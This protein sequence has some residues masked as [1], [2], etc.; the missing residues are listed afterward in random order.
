MLDLIRL[1]RRPLFPP[2]GRDLCRQVALLTD[3]HE[4]Q[5]LLV[6]PSGLAV[7]VEYFVREHGVNGSGV[8]PDPVLHD[9]AEER[10]R[11][12]GLLDRTNL[13]TGRADQLPFRDEIFDVVVGELGLTSK[14]DPGEA[15]AELIRVTRPGGTVVLVQPS[16]KAPVDANR[17]KVL[18]EHLGARP[19][20]LVEWK[21]LLVDG[22]LEQLHTEDWS[23]EETAFR[24]QV[25]KPFP[26]FE[27]LFTLREKLG[28]LRRAWGRWGWRGVWTALAREQEVHNLLTRERILGLDLVKALKAGVD[29]RPDVPVVD[30]GAAPPDDGKSVDHEASARTLEGASREDDMEDLP[31]FSEAAEPTRGAD[32]LEEEE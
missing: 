5:E 32:N 20:M 31:L 30:T 10:L 18:S 21:R 11:T 29:S 15:V 13:Q 17:R 4:G 24:P 3:L 28:I 26:D 12:E 2:G 16:W 1:S 8:E 6:V 22:G 9:Q 19:L 7:T 25:S 27:E 23:D 14:A